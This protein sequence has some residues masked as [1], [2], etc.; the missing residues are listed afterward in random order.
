[1]KLI[2]ATFVVVWW[3]ALWGIFDTCMDGKSK[4]EKLNIYL[5]LLCVIL[6][7][8]CFYPKLLCKL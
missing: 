5:L 3:I 8:V 1:M 6:I 4:E 7:I 2:Y